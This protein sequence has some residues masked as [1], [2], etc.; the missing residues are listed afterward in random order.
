MR[1]EALA[2]GGV[3]RFLGGLGRLGLGREDA[4]AEEERDTKGLKSEK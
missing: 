4:G 1:I 2:E 3:R